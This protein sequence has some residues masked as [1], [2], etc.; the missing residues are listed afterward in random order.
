MIRRM[1]MRLHQKSTKGSNANRD[2]RRNKAGL[3]DWIYEKAH[4][5]NKS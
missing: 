4:V 2:N 1:Q 5:E 3:N